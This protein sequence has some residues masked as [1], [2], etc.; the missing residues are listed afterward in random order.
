MAGNVKRP[1][2]E[3]VMGFTVN[4][5]RNECRPLAAITAVTTIKVGPGLLKWGYN[6]VMAGSDKHCTRKGTSVLFLLTSKE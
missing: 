2:E 5:S 6:K 3:T 1:K 4:Y